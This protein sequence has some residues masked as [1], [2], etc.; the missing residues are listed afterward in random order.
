MKNHHEVK[1]EDSIVGTKVE[2]K[3]SFDKLLKRM[4]TDEDEEE[5]AH[6]FK[7]N[8]GTIIE[9]HGHEF[10][11]EVESGSFIIHKMYVKKVH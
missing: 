6:D 2:S 8:G 5:V 1:N 3:I 9:S 10:L 7:E 4:Q 11:I